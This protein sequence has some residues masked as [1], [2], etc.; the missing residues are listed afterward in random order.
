MYPDVANGQTNGNRAHIAAKQA[1]KQELKDEHNRMKHEIT[2]LETQVH[3]LAESVTV[4][5]GLFHSCTGDNDG[6]VA[7]G[8][9]VEERFCDICEETK[10][11]ERYELAVEQARD[12]LSDLSSD[13]RRLLRIRFAV[14]TNPTL[15]TEQ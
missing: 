15:T 1:N 3:E 7:P 11:I 9:L 13:L 4:A 12:R 5:P 2:S 10:E 14:G 8:P 6:G